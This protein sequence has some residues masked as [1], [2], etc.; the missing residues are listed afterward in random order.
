MSEMQDLSP[1]RLFVMLAASMFGAGSADL[2]GPYIVIGIGA[3]GGS[4]VMIMQRERSDG[5]IRA[6]VYFWASTMLALFM[7]VPVAIVAAKA[8]EPLQEQWL[9][10]PVAF[11]LGFVGDKWTTKIFPWVGARLGKW[12]DSYLESRTHK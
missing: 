5:N 10:F 4:A 12:L 11:L 2:I 8:Y 9:F 1:V 6:F 7:T 3:A